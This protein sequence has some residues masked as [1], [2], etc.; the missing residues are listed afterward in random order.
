MPARPALPVDAVLP[1]LVDAVQTHPAAVLRAPAGAGK[2]TRVPP[3]LLDSGMGKAGNILVLQPRRFAARA[4]ARR[5]AV[6]RGEAVGATIGY[7]VRFERKI[8]PGTRVRVMTEGVLL[9]KLLDDPFLE[10][11]AVIVFDEFHER[12]LEADLALGMVR[13]VQETV[14][15]ELKIVVMS[16]TLAAEPIAAYLGGCPVIECEG[17]MYPVAIEY[18][19]ATDR[20]SLAEL[21]ARGVRQM[22]E[23]TEGDILTFLPGVGEIRQAATLLEDTAAC[24]GLAVM[25][26]FGDLPPEQQ[27]AVL[28][29]IDRR[30]IVLATNVA[31]TSVTIEGVTGVVD[32]GAARVLRYDPAVGLDRLELRPISRAS[33][34]QR[35]GRAGRTQPGVCLR[36]WPRAADMGRPEFEEPEIRRLDLAGAALKLQSWDEP[37]VSRFPWFEAPRPEAV[38]RASHFLRLIGA[39]DENGA[40]DLG[41]RLARLP[42]HPRLGRLLIEGA[43]RGVIPRAA[44]AAALLSERDPW[45]REEGGFRQEAAHASQSDLLDRVVVLEEYEQR[46]SRAAAMLHRGG[47]KAVLRARDQLLRETKAMDESH[48]NNHPTDEDFLRSV[49]AAFPD[50]IALRR[51]PHAPRGLMVGGR[52][53]RLATGSAVKD[54]ELFVCVDVQDAGSEAVVR[55]A[56][57][58]ERDWLPRA[59]LKTQIAVTFDEAQERLLARRRLLWQDLVLEESPTA[60]PLDATTAEALAQHAAA[61]WERAFPTDDAETMN[62]VQRV[63]CL[64]QWAPDLNLPSLDDAQLRELLPTLC[65]G[66][67]SLAEVR[68]AP[69]LTTLQALFTWEQLQTIEREAPPRLRLPKGR[70]A[71]LEYQEGKPPILAARV[72]ELFGVRETPRIARGRVPVLLH[73]LAPNY[74]VQQVTDDLASFWRNTYPQVRKDLRGRYPKH[75]WPEDP[76]GALEK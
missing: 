51:E 67:R 29:P 19:T 14:R 7:Q 35:A 54:A 27:D 24:H 21:A 49:L 73:L 66:R 62:F 32:T 53:V 26:L 64:R 72:Q 3:A 47:A 76:L 5:M 28:A 61:R 12:S 74:R 30:K 37:D 60:L 22:L 25:P 31:E 36:M 33:A 20:A 15:P 17:R 58:V 2:T 18:V 63:R 59:F 42:V 44:L 45:V 55:I 10:D 75:A 43:R 71:S 1:A 56:S 8:G 40:T 46:D 4:T 69:W 6:E 9:R 41:R 48:T 16:A 52:G 13:R 39:I 57:A 70:Q 38:E 11:V 68:A 50:R 65:Q 34:Q 23:M